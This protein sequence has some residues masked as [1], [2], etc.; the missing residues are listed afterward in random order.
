MKSSFVIFFLILFSACSDSIENLNK[1]IEF[2]SQ[3]PEDLRK[4]SE[5]TEDLSQKN[6]LDPGELNL[7]VSKIKKDYYEIFFDHFYSNKT[8]IYDEKNHKIIK[9]ILNTLSVIVFIEQNIKEKLSFIQ[10]NER[11]IYFYRNQLIAFP[12]SQ[13]VP[14]MNDKIQKLKEKIKKI[15]YEIKNLY[16]KLDRQIQNMKGYSIQYKSI[17]HDLL[18]I[19]AQFASEKKE[20]CF[21]YE[22]L[23]EYLIVGMPF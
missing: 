16:S 4:R 12:C 18:S 23:K 11:S 21:F 2:S 5:K 14:R 6:L 17:A 20:F 8:R 19:V 3:N 10:S 15:S 1:N 22:K 9:K 13:G 7:D